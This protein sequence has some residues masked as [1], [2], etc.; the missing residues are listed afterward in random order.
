M[1]FF[2]FYIDSGSYHDPISTRSCD[3]A[4][5]TPSGGYKWIYHGQQGFSASV[6]T[7]W[8]YPN[9][10]RQYR[11]FIFRKMFEKPAFPSDNHAEEIVRHV[12]DLTRLDSRYE[13][14]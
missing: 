10:L 11:D 9:A 1:P 14:L 3:R 5:A 12:R 4:Q 2:Y 6:Y 8:L 13:A 7:K